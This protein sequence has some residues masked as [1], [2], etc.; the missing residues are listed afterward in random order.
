MVAFGLEALAIIASLASIIGLFF[1]LQAWRSA[2]RA[3]VGAKRAED[4]ARQAR[5]EVRR[6]NAADDLQTLTAMAKDLLTCVEN[7]H[8]QAACLQARDLVSGVNEAKGRW[9]GI[10]PADTRG[11]LNATG[12][13]VSVVA[14]NLSIRGGEITP[15]ERDRLLRFCHGV[16][17]TLATETGKIRLLNEQE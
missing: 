5:E 8:I 17:T 2:K 15:E 4:A 16:V 6:G 12:K 3:E 10:F 9:Q 7:G 1:S 14:R 11:E 13:Q